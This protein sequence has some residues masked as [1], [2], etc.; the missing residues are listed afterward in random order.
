MESHH[1]RGAQFGHANR[2]NARAR[3]ALAFGCSGIVLDVCWHLNGLTL[4]VGVGV[5]VSGGQTYGRAKKVCIGLGDVI[6]ESNHGDCSW[7]NI[8]GMLTWHAD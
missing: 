1:R 2:A 5:G 4:G 3:V 6:V 7:K 8:R